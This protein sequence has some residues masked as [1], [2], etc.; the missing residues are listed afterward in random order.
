MASSLPE[1]SPSA[2][3]T[4]T[5]TDSDLVFD[6][7]VAKFKSRLNRTQAEQFAKCTIDDVRNQI[8]HIQN[9]HGSQRRLRNMD[10]LSKFVEGMVHLGKVVEVFLNLHN[11]VALIWGPIKFLLLAASNWIDSLD[12]LLGVYGQI[13]EVLPNLTRYGQIYKEYPYAHTHLESYY[14]DI[15]EF[16]SN[17]LDVFARPGWK[18]LFHSAWKTFKTQF[19]PILKSLERHRIMLS[20]EKLTAV[21]EETQKQG[22][23]IQDKLDQLHRQLQ[24]RDQKNAE[25]DLTAHQS[26]IDQQYST[27]ESKIDAPNYYED[28]EIASQKRFQNTSGRWILS[29]PLVSEW[30]DHSSKANGTIYLSGI[31]GAGKTVLTSSIIG[32]LKE[33]RSSSKGSADSFSI[34]YFY[35]KHHQRKKSSLLSLLLALLAQL[36]A[37]DE[38]LLEHVYQACRSAEPQQFRSLDE[39]SRHVSTALQSQSRCFVIIDG[40]DECTEASRVLEWFESIMSKQDDTSRDTDF[41]IRLFISG[42]RDGIL[43]SQMSH[44]TRI[45]LE[46]S[47]GHDQDI[48]AF[49]ATMAIK[50]RERFS[51][52]PGVEQDIALRVTS[53]AGGMFLYAQLVLNNLFSQTSKYDLKQELKAETFPEGLEQAYERVVVRVLKTPNKAERAVA[54]DILGMIMSACRPLHWR[55]IQSKFCIDPSKG[56]ADIDR[57]LVISC[58]HICSSLV[59]VSYLDPSVSSPGE[60]IIDLVHTTAKIYL[61]QTKEIDLQT[62]NAKMALFC[63]E[64]M[65]SRPLTSG[66]P[67]L[68]IQDYASKGYYGFHDYAVAFWWKHI[69]QVLAASELDTELARKVLRTADRYVTDT[70][71]IEQIEAFD[72][73]SKE[74]QSLKRKLEGIPQN[75]RDWDSMRIYEMRAVAVRDAIEVLI[76]QPY[77]QKEATLALYGPWRY[78]C[79]KPWCQ[80]FSRG[81]ED[82]QQQQIHINQHELPFTCEYQGCHATEVGFGTETDLKTH[83]RRWHPKEEPSLF[84]APKRHTPSHSDILKTVRMGDLNK[85]KNLIEQVNISPDYQR[86]GGKSLLELAVQNGHLHIVQYLTAMGANVNVKV[87]QTRS[88]LDVAVASRDLEIVTF[89]CNLNSI[90][91]DEGKPDYNT[92]AVCAMLDPFPQAIMAQLLRTASL[93]RSQDLLL[94]AIKSKNAT[95]VAYFAEALDASCFDS[96][97]E[98]AATTAH[99]PCLDALLSSGKT[100]PNARDVEGALP[101]HAACASGALPIVQRLYAVTTTTHIK[102]ASGNTPLHLASWGGHVAVVE[103]LIRKGADIN[104]TNKDLE[105]PL[106][107]AIR[108]GGTAV[109]KLLLENGARLDTVDESAGALP[110]GNR[111]MGMDNSFGPLFEGGM[112]LANPLSSADITNEFDFDS[113]L[114]DQ[115]GETSAFN[116]EEAFPM[117][118]E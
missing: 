103:F 81:F 84:P 117:A 32:H 40:L 59:D 118:C 39:V 73:S 27:V 7:A 17:A 89:L 79:R 76:N 65:I 55:E 25:R 20:E 82:A 1:T 8:R 14:C 5:R 66:L 10:R 51:L 67:K 101:L 99:L 35:F 49:T 22:H 88:L 107:F 58:K 102:Y 94:F 6:K 97:L 105:T 113:F 13:G 70:G 41:N 71:E 46:T 28:Y 48:E 44:Y 57:K 11:G 98:V 104:A 106:Q 112:E 29:H 21:M 38:S 47:S 109:R 52:D 4:Q 12:S 24:E 34:S 85:V 60:E 19:D 50:I 80:F 74:I 36:V 86:K 90:S 23:S 114:R 61:V 100:D 115:D 96:A 2:G 26:R 3:G 15:L 63:A 42:Q 43:E 18:V 111:M 116:F 54:K 9:R 95:A 93:K 37:Q 69:Q 91:L 53:K 77:E 83:A 68:E 75:L 110:D 64:Y 78:K 45:D 87:R 62:E 33:R 16:H 31:P 56:E 108:N 92:L 72:D 30:L